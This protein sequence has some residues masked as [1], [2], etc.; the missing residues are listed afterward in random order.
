MSLSKPIPDHL[1][2]ISSKLKN[3]LSTQ[4]KIPYYLILHAVHL[5][6]TPISFDELHE[7]LINK[8]ITLQQEHSLS[9]T[10]PAIGNPIAPPPRL[11]YHYPSHQRHLFPPR[12][13]ILSQASNPTF[14]KSRGNRPRLFLGHCQW[15]RVQGNT[16]CNTLSF[17]SLIQMFN[18]HHLLRLLHSGNQAPLGN[19]NLM[20]QLIPRNLISLLT[21][22]PLI[23]LD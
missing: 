6:G 23:M 14:F 5:D 1:E 15:C 8:E 3:K 9:F 16:L 12:P 18:C 7:K 13:S 4:Q 2:G 17:G 22:R 11:G 10:V 19:H 21:V 20:Q